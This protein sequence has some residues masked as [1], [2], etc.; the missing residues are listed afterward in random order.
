MVRVTVHADTDE[1]L[2][3]E[4]LVG[5]ATAAAERALRAF[6]VD[7]RGTRDVAPEFADYELAHR[8]IGK[9]GLPAG[10][11]I[12]L[13]VDVGDRTRE[14]FVLAATNA[15][16]LVRVLTDAASAVAWLQR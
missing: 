14:F 16:H 10:S 2:A 9:S 1:A 5:A 6:L 13:L 4:L 8:L 11:R 3:L 15:G 12:A 7:L